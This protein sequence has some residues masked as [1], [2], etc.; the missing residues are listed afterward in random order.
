MSPGKKLGADL[1]GEFVDVC[2]EKHQM[3]PN[4]LKHS[5]LEGHYR[6]IMI[7]YIV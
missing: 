6:T 3:N 7:Q 5:C 2:G 4:V 1:F